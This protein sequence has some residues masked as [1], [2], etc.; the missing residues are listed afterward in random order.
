M[1]LLSVWQ[2]ATPPMLSAA[3]EPRWVRTFTMPAPVYST[4][5]ASLEA[6]RLF[7]DFETKVPVKTLYANT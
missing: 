3:E 1:A 7:S 5:Y 2:R 6:L 4:M